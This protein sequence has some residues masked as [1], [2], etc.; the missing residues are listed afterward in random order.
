MLVSILNGLNIY[1][2]ILNKNR[3]ILF[4][5][6]VFQEALNIKI[7]D[8]LGLR[9]G[10]MLKCKFANKSGHGCGTSSECSLCLAKNLVVDT[11][12]TGKNSEGQVSI[13]SIINGLEMTSTFYEKVTNINLG[14]DNFY[15]VAFVDKSSEMERDNLEHIFYHDILNSASSLY[16]IIRLL[17]MENDKYNND[18]EIEMIE[19]YIQNIIDDIEYHRSISSAENNNLTISSEEVDV[20]DLVMKVANML[21]KDG[22]FH[23][24]EVDIN[25][26]LVNKNIKTDR[27]ILKR[28]FIN[29]L[30]NAMEVNNNSIIRIRTEETIEYIHIIFQNDEIIPSEHQRNIFLKRYSSKSVNRGYG[31]YGS[32]LL[33]M[34][35]LNGNIEFKSNEENGT[36]FIVSL[37]K[38]VI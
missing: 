12:H 34:K 37:P 31:L 26:A 24:I 20:N 33:L 7:E 29:L 1:V 6:E 5:N 15:M 18:L 38:E 17:K 30:K 36:E 25:L 32:K 2:I 10:D 3:Q 8:V 4:V 14:S 27:L 9:P 19:G 21:K 22:R 28:I 23:H 11:I 35:Y 16:N 13:L